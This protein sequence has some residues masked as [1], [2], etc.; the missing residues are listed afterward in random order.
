MVVREISEQRWSGF[1]YETVS[2]CR[3][4][5]TKAF[6][7]WVPKTFKLMFRVY[8]KSFAHASWCAIA[9]FMWCTAYKPSLNDH[10]S[11]FITRDIFPYFSGSQELYIQ[12]N[13]EPVVFQGVSFVSKL[14]IDL[15]MISTILWKRRLSDKVFASIFNISNQLRTSMTYTCGCSW[16][17]LFK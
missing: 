8:N 11:S 2:F 4:R 6:G 17:Q 12:F 5:P 13:E 1:L 7:S 9:K 15:R 10:L 14:H 16:Y 3:R